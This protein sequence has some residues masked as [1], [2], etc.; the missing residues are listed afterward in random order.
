MRRRFLVKR[1]LAF[2]TI[3]Q[4]DHPNVKCADGSKIRRG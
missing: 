2:T 1:R 3:W 4:A